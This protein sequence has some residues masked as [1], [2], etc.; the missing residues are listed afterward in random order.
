[1]S[2][3]LPSL[4]IHI[5]TIHFQLHQPLKNTTGALPFM[6]YNHII[7]IRLSFSH[8]IDSHSD[9]IVQHQ[10]RTS[11]IV[12]TLRCDT[13]RMV[14]IKEPDSVPICVWAD[15]SYLILWP[16]PST[17]PL[18]LFSSP[19]EDSL[20]SCWGPLQFRFMEIPPNR[21]LLSQ[22]DRQRWWGV[23]HSFW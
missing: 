16:P 12:K 10:R 23:H 6:L 21:K 2:V 14:S 3:Y 4:I 5:D 17:S 11:G 8:Y 19:A 18:C 1:M 7:H 9:R 20:S 13:V 15:V 22:D